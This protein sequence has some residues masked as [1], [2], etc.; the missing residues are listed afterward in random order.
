[1]TMKKIFSVIIFSLFFVSMALAVP[2]PKQKNQ[3]NARTANGKVLPPKPTNI[4]R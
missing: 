4:R 1:M 3:K 2:H